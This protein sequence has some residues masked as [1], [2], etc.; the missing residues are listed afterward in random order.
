VTDMEIEVKVKVDA[1]EIADSLRPEQLAKVFCELPSDEQ[2][3]F[4]RTVRETMNGWDEGGGQMQL[5]HIG[6]EINGPEDEGVR[7]WLDSLLYFSL[8]DHEKQL[9]QVAKEFESVLPGRVIKSTPSADDAFARHIEDL[10]NRPANETPEQAQERYNRY[11]NGEGILN[12]CV[13]VVMGDIGEP[14]TVG[15]IKEILST[16]RRSARIDFSDIRPTGDPIER[17]D[18]CPDCKG[19]GHYEGF[20]AVEDC[21][22]CDGRGKL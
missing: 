1:Q 2:A 21:K 14:G 15:T 9:E 10:K 18:D 11:L 8:V 3:Q 13:E 7:E 20:T 6:D 16:P 12:P 4:F 17:S 19:T 22:T 5:C